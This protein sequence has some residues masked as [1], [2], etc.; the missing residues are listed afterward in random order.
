MYCRASL[1]F[2]VGL[3]FSLFI[4]MCVHNFYSTDVTCVCTVL[5]RFKISGIQHAYCACVIAAMRG[6]ALY[7]KNRVTSYLV[8]S[9]NRLCVC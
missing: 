9:F 6:A 4:Y 5:V 7:H 8:L 3:G 1:L 2:N